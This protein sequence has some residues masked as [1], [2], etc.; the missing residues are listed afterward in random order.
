[1][2]SF[3]LQVLSCVV[4]VAIASL[5]SDASPGPSDFKPVTN[6]SYKKKQELLDIA[7]TKFAETDK[8]KYCYKGFDRIKSLKSQ[9]VPNGYI[10]E[11]TTRLCASKKYIGNCKYQ[12]PLCKMPQE[13]FLVEMNWDV[14]L[15]R[16]VYVKITK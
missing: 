5:T 13:P 4:L 1:M 2:L 7:L 10:Y 14:Q 11:F 15:K 3:K 8:Q 9:D 12:E 16:P 6:L